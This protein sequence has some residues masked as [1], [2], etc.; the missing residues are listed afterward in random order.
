[1]EQEISTITGGSLVL[2]LCLGVLLLA[3]PRRY[4]LLPLFI[5]GCYMTLGQI[6]L[7]GP[8]HFSIFRILLFF[9]WI[10]IVIRK[11][12]ASIKLNSIDKV[13]I[14]W[15]VVSAIM[16]IML[17]GFSEAI[18]GRLG[19]AYNAV[20]T[21]FLIRAL[22]WDLEDILQAVKMLGIII[23]PLAVIFI[24]E[25]TT[26]RNV[27]SFLGGV[28]EI[29]GIRNNR[30]RCQGPFRNPILAGTFGAT[31]LPLFVGLWFNDSRNRLIAA[32]AILAA[33]IIVITSSSSGPL[34]AYLAGMVGLLL[35]FYRQHLRIL[36][37]GGV[38][39]LL[40]LHI[41]MKAPVWYLIAR[42]SGMLGMG[43]GW[44]RSELIDAAIRHFDEWW[45]IG[46]TYTAHWMPYSLEINPNMADITNQFISE[47][48]T[49]G[50]LSMCLFIGLIIKCF[51]MIGPVIHSE[52]Q[53]SRH[54]RI[55]I[56]SLGCALFGHVASF[57][58]VTYF[59]QIIIFWYLL[60][61]M[62]ATLAHIDVEVSELEIYVIP[63]SD[64][65]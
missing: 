19:L 57:I 60:I 46:T 50:L 15:V 45:L 44:H 56:W 2:T 47:G 11:E 21:Y 63:S 49:G 48:V 30:L 18:V 62:I 12:I 36:L 4:A 29:T 6:L 23:I 37:W 43:T 59:D 35:W 13:L 40:A 31:A 16:N 25:M 9:G 54:D 20:G 17:K 22:I 34:L 24:V 1:M 28:P 64:T 38:F 33:T 39:S 58:S 51:K 3:L 32:G 61:A 26:G 42:M 52:F 8:F 41:Y 14:A 7:V 27:F 10:R 65:S 55:M 53:L 5:S